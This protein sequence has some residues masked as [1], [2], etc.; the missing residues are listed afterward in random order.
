MLVV[1]FVLQMQM[2]N[3]QR[4]SIL[5]PQPSHHLGQ[6]SSQKDALI[7]MLLR[8]SESQMP[9]E[10][11]NLTGLRQSALLLPSVPVQPQHQHPPPLQAQVLQGKIPGIR[12]AT[13]T[14]STQP[15]PLGGP[16]IQPNP[17]VQASKGLIRQIQ[18]PVQQ[19]HARPTGA[20]PL[21][22][23]PHLAIPNTSLQQLLLP[24]PSVSQASFSTAKCLADYI[25]CMHNS[26]IKV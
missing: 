12:G 2:T 22:Q 24:H 17:P 14:S 8:P 18:H 20:A 7:G 19:H 16:S 23:H 5:A 15:Q 21:A 9:N 3:S 25:C 10:P 26:M 1:I 13:K 11:Q 4:S 6:A